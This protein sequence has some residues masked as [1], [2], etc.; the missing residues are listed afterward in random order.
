MLTVTE[1]IRIGIL[2]KCPSDCRD[3]NGPPGVHRQIISL[4][5]NLDQ[6][7]GS[8]RVSTNRDF[9][10]RSEISLHVNQNEQNELCNDI[11]SD[12][13][14]SVAGDSPVRENTSNQSSHNRKCERFVKHVSMVQNTDVQQVQVD[15]DTQKEKTTDLQV[16][17]NVLSQIFKEDI[18]KSNLTSVGLVLDQAQVDIL[19]N[20]WRCKN[21]DRLSA[22][23]EDYKSCFPIHDSSVDY[24]QVP[25]LDDLLE[26]LLRQTH[27]QK[28][29]NSWD[30]HRQLFSQP[31]KQIEK[32]GFQ[33]QL[34]ARMNIIS[35]MYIQQALGSLLN[36]I[37]NG[38]VDKDMICQTIKDV[39]AMSQK[40]LD[41]SGRTGAFFHLIRRKA[42]A[43]DSGLVNLKDMRSKCQYLPLTGDGVFGKGLETCLEKR[44]EQREQLSELLPEFNRKRKFD[45]DTRDSWSSTNKIPKYNSSEQNNSNARGNNRVTGSSANNSN[46]RKPLGQ[47]DFN[48]NVPKQDGNK[49]DYKG[50]K[51]STQSSWGSFRIPK[52]DS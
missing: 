17:N 8:P 32:L 2:L 42:T 7:L 3:T 51:S 4:E 37:D 16:R 35:V 18:T 40:T 47:K 50:G 38:E 14:D 23:K 24:L 46:Y 13:D 52:K 25:S 27:G 34:A 49:K 30:S 36:C 39:F 33:G 28:A 9:D 12:D 31:L 20:S 41:Q 26:P 10:V 1:T 43:Q 21:P 22:Y 29:V 6:D 44:K 45:Y 15:K 11:R 19:D 5:P 48:K